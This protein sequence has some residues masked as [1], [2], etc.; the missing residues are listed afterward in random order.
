MED[1]NEIIDVPQPPADDKST[2]DACRVE[3][4]AVLAKHGCDIHAILSAEPVGNG[5]DKALVS[6]NYT[7]LPG[8][9]PEG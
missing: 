4:R 1:I 8:P 5:K 2:L 6:A 7:I 3:L 9:P